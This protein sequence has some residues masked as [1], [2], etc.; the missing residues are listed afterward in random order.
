VCGSPPYSLEMVPHGHDK[1]TVEQKKSEW[2][3]ERIGGLTDVTAVG[4]TMLEARRQTVAKE[5]G[6]Q[7]EAKLDRLVSKENGRPEAAPPPP[8]KKPPDNLPS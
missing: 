3:G 5:V 1:G 4:S 6:E 2:T 8:Q 7:M